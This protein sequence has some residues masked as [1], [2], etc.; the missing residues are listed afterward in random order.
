MRACDVIIVR[1]VIDVRGGVDDDNN[2]DDG[3]DDDA[4]LA[5]FT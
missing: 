4:L 3:D 1:A 5:I 2:N